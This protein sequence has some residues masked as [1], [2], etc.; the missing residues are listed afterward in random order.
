[1]GKGNELIMAGETLDRMAMQ[2]EGMVSAAKALKG[3]GSI[4]NHLEELI[5][6]RDAQMK[7]IDALENDIA[8]ANDAL[9]AVRSKIENEKS[10]AEMFAA[11]QK[12]I[13]QAEANEIITRANAAAAAVTEQT[14]TVIEGKYADVAAEEAKLAELVAFAHEGVEKAK[15]EQ[16]SAENERD[17]A[18]AQYDKIQEA[19]RAITAGV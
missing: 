5:A 6:K 18:Q 17:A 2:Y 4:E 12:D 8:D 10:Q 1:M 19:I 7:T 16:K 3:I 15:A 13:A 14:N 9:D 11:A